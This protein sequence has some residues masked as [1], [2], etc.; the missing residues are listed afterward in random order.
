M[1]INMGSFPSMLFWVGS[2]K[3]RYLL[4]RPAGEGVTFV[5]D[6]PWAGC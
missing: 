1:L 3:V 5:K 2:Y 4:P 6:N